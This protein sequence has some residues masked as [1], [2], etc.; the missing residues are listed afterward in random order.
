VEQ[1]GMKEVVSC[2]ASA[3]ADMMLRQLHGLEDDPKLASV[4][5]GFDCDTDLT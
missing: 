1:L 2:S 4:L 5:I 3:P